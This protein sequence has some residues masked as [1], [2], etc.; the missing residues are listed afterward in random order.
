VSLLVAGLA[1]AIFLLLKLENFFERRL[2][3][4]GGDFIFA[5]KVL[6]PS[7]NNTLVSARA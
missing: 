5:V 3:H 6:Y 4:G 1:L 7:E 2:G